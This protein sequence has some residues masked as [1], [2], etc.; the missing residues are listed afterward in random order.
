MRMFS[1]RTAMLLALL[2]AGGQ[3]GWAQIVP[4][5]EIFVGGSYFQAT[6]KN[7]L[8][9]NLNGFALGGRYQFTSPW[10]VEATFH[11]QK[12]KD[13]PVDLNQW[14]ILVGPRYGKLMTERLEGYV[15]FLVGQSHLKAS[16][17]WDTATDSGKVY[18]PGLGVDLHLDPHWV[19]RLQGDY[20]VTA[21]GT[22]TQNN[23]S[24]TVGVAFH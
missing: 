6:P 14:L 15:H 7:G 5:H 2:L 21:Y 24:V 19:L 8:T 17:D 9:T 1:S 13:G 23:P 10:S 22:R 16:I 20:L 3:G 11:T 4:G 12:G 18:G